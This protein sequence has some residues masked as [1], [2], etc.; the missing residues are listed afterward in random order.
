MKEKILTKYE[1]A[2][3]LRYVSTL[4]EWKAVFPTVASLEIF[5]NATK[6]LTFPG[7]YGEP[8]FGEAGSVAYSILTGMSESQISFYTRMIGK[9]LTEGGGEYDLGKMRIL[10][11][12][13]QSQAIAILKKFDLEN[14][15]D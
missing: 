1:A 11:S 10:E 3:K 15:L 8:P 7:S 13:G 4:A 9:H 12:Y 5:W 6:N 14:K 2:C